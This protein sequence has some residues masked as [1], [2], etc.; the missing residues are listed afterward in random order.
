MATPSQ[1]LQWDV[2]GLQAV[3][4]RATQIADV[5]VETSGQLH[6][7]V[8]DD[9]QWQ[10]D[11]RIA[12]GDRAD[13]ERT[14]MRAIATAYDDLAAAGGGA[15]RDMAFPLAQIK[16]IIS[17]YVVAPIAIADDWTI[18]GVDDWDSEAGLQLLRLSGLATS[19]LTADDQWG[20]K[21]AA[22]NADL[23]ALA[24]AAVL[25]AATAMI[26]QDKEFDSRADPERMRTS[27]A[28]FQQMF[29]RQPANATDWVTAEAL[30]PHSY[31]PKYQ[32]VG[33]EI[34]VVRIDPVNGQGVVRAGQ[35]IEQRDVTNPFMGGDSGNPFTRNRGDNRG[36]DSNFDPEHTRVTTYVDYENGVVIMRQNPSVVQNDD[37]TP[38]EVRVGAPTGNVT[39]DSAGAVRVQY[40]AADPFEP[41][42]AKWAGLTVNGDLVFTPESNGV[43]VDGTR[44][45]YPSLEV[46]QDR[47]DHDV[48]TVLIDRADVGNSLGPMDLANHHD[49]GLGSVATNPFAETW[50]YEYD[51]PGSYYP[52][53]K[54][55]SADSPPI[56][57]APGQRTGPMI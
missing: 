2:S 5:I 37:G 41:G 7:T 38:G 50:N 31:D 57:T 55:G 8:H 35:F 1:V 19:L 15:G 24:P 52:G 27:A 16:S 9:L 54:F 17:N 30:N 6:A 36:P 34:R 33:P 53:T 43:H 13:R 10:G 46:Y 32:G 40:D 20:A 51:V 42:P 56:A 45:D 39:Q 23:N 4:D 49:I 29:G 22:A 25:A 3:A 21:I 28:A 48:H 11:A 47:P 12:A 18:T 44:T 14:E 26:Q